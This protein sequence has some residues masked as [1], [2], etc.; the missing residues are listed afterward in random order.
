MRPP[1]FRFRSACS[2]LPVRPALLALVAGGVGVGCHAMFSFDPVGSDAGEEVDA[3]DGEGIAEVDGDEDGE[4]PSECGNGTVEAG[5]ECDDGNEVAGDGCDPGCTWSCEGDG[6]CDDREV[7]NGAETCVD[8]VCRPGAPAED[9]TACARADGGDGVCRGGLCVSALCGNGAV[10]E[11]EECDDGNLDEG[12]GCLNTCRQ[13]ACGDGRVRRDH[14]ECDDGNDVAG[15]GCEPDCTWSCEGDGECDDGDVCNGAETCVE[16]VCRDAPDLPDGSECLRR[17]GSAGVCRGGACAG[18]ACG[19]GLLD[20]GEEC[21]DGNPSDTDGCTNACRLA[22]C[23][24]GFVRA[25]VELCDDGNTSDNDACLSTCRPAYCGDGFV[26]IGVEQCD[27]GNPS[28]E[29]DCLTSCRNAVCGDGFVRTGAEECDDGNLS[30]TDACLNTCREA[31]CGDG[32]VWAGMEEC[33]GAATR[34]CSTSC[35]TVGTESCVS[36]RWSGTCMPPAEA[37]NGADDDCDL[38]CDET[39][40]C[41]A[42]TAGSCSSSCGT[43]GTRFC[44]A[45]C[46]WEPCRPPVETC[47]GVDDDCDTACDNGF[48]CCA[49]RTRPCTTTCGSTGTQ[50]CTASC[51]WESICTPPGESCNGADDDCDTTCDNGFECCAGGTRPC[52]TT[53]GSTGTQ[54]CTASCAWAVG[55][56]PPAEVCNGVDDD[57]DGWTDE[58]CS[59]CTACPGATNVSGGGRYTGTLA[60]G[61]SAQTGSCGGAGAE[62]VFTFTTSETRDVFLTS[63]GSAFDTTLYV[64]DCSCAGTER[65]C[66]DDA[67]GYNTSVLFLR[68]LPAGTYNVFLDAKAAG[69]GGAWQLDIYL[70]APGATGD[71]CGDPVPIPAGATSIS[72]TIL[73]F[74]ADDVVAAG[75]DCPYPSAREDRVYYFYLPASRVVTFNGCAGAGQQ[76]DQI[77]YVRRV[78]D[79]ADPGNQAACNDDDSCGGSPSFCD[80]G[81]YNSGLTAT[82]GPGLYYF[83]VDGYH[84]GND[85]DTLGNYTFTLTGF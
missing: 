39:F 5:E 18:I 15:D 80:S 42:G 65:A 11:G 27:D 50:G 8:H 24:D 34:A 70:S 54:G 72:G 78:C 76:W 68:D 40:A 29:D 37:C 21:D 6:E 79:R 71:R 28:N 73:G 48:A 9:G 44:S 23:G 22:V 83:F 38:D 45:S 52:T 63:H 85:C 58:G 10:D 30:N 56:A 26:W 64:R 17:D 61:A 59:S 62:V 66:S 4:A 25:G 12:D 77:L 20:P 69:A 57:C 47:N 2:C 19:N 51:A 75:A 13:A 35:R 60:A 1:R 14:E 74:T 53:C 84:V 16:H 82:L 43:A 55:C 49:G 67:D 33:E 81:H 31:R 3:I 36:C 41:C 32:F 7:C 46:V